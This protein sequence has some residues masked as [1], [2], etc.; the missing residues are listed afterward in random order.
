MSHEETKDTVRL[1]SPQALALS[2]SKGDLRAF[3]A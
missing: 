3:V 2:L 1:R